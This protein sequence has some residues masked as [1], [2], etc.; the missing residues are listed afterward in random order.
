MTHKVKAVVYP[1]IL[2]AALAGIYMI[3]SSSGL[4]SLLGITSLSFESSFF[5]KN[6][7]VYVSEEIQIVNVGDLKAEPHEKTEISESEAE[8]QQQE[9][10]TPED[11]YYFAP[12]IDWSDKSVSDKDLEALYAVTGKLVEER[13]VGMSKYK[14][15]QISVTGY[16][17]ASSTLAD[18]KREVYYYVAAD[19]TL[20][21]NTQLDI[22][23]VEDSVK[24]EV[25]CT[26]PVKYVLERVVL[27]D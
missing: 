27:A 15:V 23:Y 18:F 14:G 16:K 24:K 9:A 26:I 17:P 20:Y 21:L 6:K 11:P 12:Y 5:A 7:P 1:I 3:L 4:L 13:M 8:T 22:V 19:G 25:R 2:L 10:T